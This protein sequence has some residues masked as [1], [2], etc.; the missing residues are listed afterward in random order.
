MDAEKNIE[1]YN[2]TDYKENYNSRLKNFCENYIDTDELDFLNNDLFQ[3]KSYLEFSDENVNLIWDKLNPDN[4]EELN[5]VRKDIIDSIRSYKKI[6]E[7]IEKRIKELELIKIN[8]ISEINSNAPIL[9]SIK[10]HGTP[11]QFTELIKSLI[12]LQ[13]FSPGLNQPGLSQKEVFERLRV[14]FEIDSFNEND[15]LKD[16]RKRTTTPTPF[17]N[18]LEDTLTKWIQNKD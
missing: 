15:K 14:F 7:L 16:I 6:I 5:S 17:I 1:Y 3:F 8:S 4:V 18:S 2:L 12:E 13:I 10:W 9:K 11:L